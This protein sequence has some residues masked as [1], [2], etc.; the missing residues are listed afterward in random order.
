[1]GRHLRSGRKRSQWYA[2]MPG[3]SDPLHPLVLGLTCAGH[4][5]GGVE[6][7]RYVGFFTFF[8]DKAPF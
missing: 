6:G 5:C 1:M 3:T 7:L 4:T 8:R 2:D